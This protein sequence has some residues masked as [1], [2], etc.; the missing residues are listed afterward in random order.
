MERLTN[1]II[2]KLKLVRQSDRCIFIFI[3][4]Y[5]S[6]KIKNIYK[7]ALE[8]RGGQFENFQVNYEASNEIF[9]LAQEIKELVE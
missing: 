2:K 8:K 4:I 6:K 9:K 3:F 5:N 1:S 7:F